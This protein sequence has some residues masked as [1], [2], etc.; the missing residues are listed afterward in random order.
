[1]ISEFQELSDKIDQL[2]EMAINLRR[3]NAELRQGIAATVAE[4]INTQRKLREATVR[5]EALLAKI[6]PVE[7][8]ADGEAGGKPEEEDVR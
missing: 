6:P 4:N 1:M 5:V 7:A 2:A 8:E 3:E